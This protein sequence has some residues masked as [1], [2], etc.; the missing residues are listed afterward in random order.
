MGTPSL[1]P[2]F[3]VVHYVLGYYDGILEGVADYRGAP[4]HF[5]LEHWGEEP[6]G[7]YRLTAVPPGIF[8]A[9]SESWDI[10]CRWVLA[11]RA[12][13]VESHS[14][15]DP[16]LPADEARRRKLK[17]IVTRWMVSGKPR[18]FLMSADF[19]PLLQGAQRGTVR[20][21]LQVR[22]TTVGDDSRHRSP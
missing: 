18:R 20:G 3:E 4:H 15:R 10:W 7:L 8:A 13:E 6:D 16:A 2:G 21:A 9:M 1:E 19:E 5:K 11:Q 14:S 22:W 17:R 12:G